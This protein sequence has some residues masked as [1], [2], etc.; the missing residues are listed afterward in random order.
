MGQ[1]I[2]NSDIETDIFTPRSYQIELLDKAKKEN[3]IIPL[4]T[5]TGKTFVAVM[6]IKELSA[7]IRIPFE[8]GGKR[9]F[10]LVDKVALVAQQAEQIR[11][12]SDL[13]VGEHHGM[14]SVDIWNSDRWRE[15]LV[16]NQ[17]I[18][19]TA[20]IFYDLLNHGFFRM[21]QV[22]LIVFDECH[23]ASKNHPYNLIMK[24]YIETPKNKRP[25]ILGLTAS[26][27]NERC[28]PKHLK[29][30][31]S[32]LEA[33]LY[34]KVQSSNDV[35]TVSKYG[36]KP[37]IIVLNAQDFIKPDISY[38]IDSLLKSGLQFCKTADYHPEFDVDPTKPVIEA[39][40]K[41]I[42][43]HDQMG[44]WCFWKVSRFFSKNLRKLEQY[45]LTNE[46][47]S[48]LR[49]GASCLELC[50]KLVESRCSSIRK[51]DDVLPYISTR[52]KRLV[53]VLEREMPAQSVGKDEIQNDPEEDEENNE[54]N[55]KQRTRPNRVDFSCLVFVEQRCVAFA[56]KIFLKDLKRWKRYSEKPLNFIRP[57]YIVGYS[58]YKLNEDEALSLHRRQEEVLKKFRLGIINLICTTSVLEE[59]IDVK[60]C[61]LVVRYDAP[62]NFRSFVQSR[63]RARK[64]NS[65]YYILCENKDKTLIICQLQQFNQI[66]KILL[67]H[68]S[69][70]EDPE[71]LEQFDHAEL[72]TIVPPYYVDVTDKPHIVGKPRVSMLTAIALVNR[73]CARLP[74]D[75]F[76]KLVPKCIVEPVA[77]SQ[78]SNLTCLYQATLRL[79]IN[80]P[81]KREVVVRVTSIP[82]ASKRLAQMAASLEACKILHKEGELDDNLLPLGKESAAKVLDFLIGVDDD[83][84]DA[85]HSAHIRP[86]SSKRKRY[87][88]KQI[89]QCLTNAVPEPDSECYLHVI[90]L[91]LNVSADKIVNY[92][93]TSI[94]AKNRKITD[95]HDSS[96]WFGILSSKALPTLPRFPLYT[97]QGEVLCKVYTSRKKVT[98]S[99]GQMVLVQKF[100]EYLFSEILRLDKT[101]M[102][103][104]PSSVYCNNTL[105]IVPILRVLDDFE[106]DYQFVCNITTL[107][108][109]L[110][111][112]PSDFERMNFKFD[113]EKFLDSVVMPW[114]RNN[115]TPYFYYVAEII[116]RSSPKSPFP[117]NVYPSFNDYFEQK[118]GLT[119]YNQDQNLLDV[120]YTSNRLNLMLPRNF[121]RR[122]YE[123]SSPYTAGPSKKIDNNTNR[124]NINLNE[125]Q[126]IK[127]PNVL[128]AYNQRQVLVP[129]LVDIHPIPGIMWH[130]I[131]CLP[132]V[133]Y[134]LNSLLNA[135]DLR[136]QIAKEAFNTDEIE[137]DVPDEFWPDL[138]YGWQKNYATIEEIPEQNNTKIVEEVRKEHVVNRA[139]TTAI[140]PSIRETRD[141]FDI[142]VWDPTSPD[143]V[144]ILAQ[145]EVAENDVIV[146]TISSDVNNATFSEDNG[147]R[148]I[149]GDDGDEDDD[150]DEDIYF[151]TEFS[152]AIMQIDQNA[153]SGRTLNGESHYKDLFKP[154]SNIVPTGWGDES[155][156]MKQEESG[157]RKLELLCTPNETSFLNT[158]ALLQD[159]VS[160]G[161]GLPPPLL[162]QV[163]NNGDGE[164]E[165]LT[166]SAPTNST[167]S[168]NQ[169]DKPQNSNLSPVE[170]RDYDDI[171]RLTPEDQL[172]LND[173]IDFNASIIDESHNDKS[174]LILIYN[175]E[176]EVYNARPKSISLKETERMIEDEI[177]L[178]DFDQPIDNSKVENLLSD[179]MTEK[180]SKIEKQSSILDD[181]LNVASKSDEHLIDFNK[182][183][184]ENEKSLIATIDQHGP[185]NL[186]GTLMPIDKSVV[187][188]KNEEVSLIEEPE[189]LTIFDQK[190]QDRS[191]AVFD[192]EMDARNSIIYGPSPSLI[193]QALTM[194]NA[195]DGFNLERLE[196]VGD[197]FLKY[198]VTMFLFCQYDKMHE[199][200]LSFLRSKQVSNFNLYKLGKKKGLGKIICST[201][202]EPCDN[203]LPPGYLSLDNVD[204]DETKYE[205]YDNLLE[206]VLEND[207][208]PT[209]DGTLPNADGGPSL[210]LEL[211][212]PPG[213]A[214][215]EQQNE[216]IIPYNLLTQHSVPDK[217]IADSVEALI[218]VYL[219]TYGPKGALQFMKW[220]GLKVLPEGADHFVKPPSPLLHFVDDPRSHLTELW[221]KFNFGHFERIIGY[222]FNDKAYVIQAFTHAS[223]YYNRITDCYQRL[224]FLGDAVLDY[225]ITRHLFEDKRK[226]S[227]GVL[228]DLR[229]AL[230]NNTIFAS[231]AVKWKLNQFFMSICPGL[232]TII[233]SFVDMQEQRQNEANFDEQLYLLNEEDEIDDEEEDIEVPK[234]LG[235]V[236]ESIAGAIYL[237]SGCSL[238]TVWKVYH[239][240]MK[241]QIEK[242][243]SN[244]P[245]S[246]IREL[247]ELCPEKVKFSKHERIVTAGKIRVMVDVQDVGRFTGLGRSYRIAKCTA[248]KRALKHL[249]NM[250]R[251]SQKSQE[252]VD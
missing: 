1:R 26:L 79:P 199:G 108:G 8:K 233:K 41:A 135:D 239:R 194:T 158:G 28:D 21:D 141:V 17:V 118:Y 5:G 48:F 55:E 49:S 147:H 15:E 60:Q 227:P 170:N 176:S 93:K 150:D 20:Q 68:C 63:G 221:T 138:D 30:A 231:L 109:D 67:E 11:T 9:S 14:K 52:L 160:L 24:H 77:T 117:D 76:T 153:R 130:I 85:R 151:S 165:K 156:P 31:I 22:N 104:D 192:F 241:D 7:D 43:V 178:I 142:G 162:P 230:V 219:T 124:S 126:E 27:I 111:R 200:K 25:R 73:Y 123:K 161:A 16:Q 243:C 101:T 136:C 66:E 246:P 197:S 53:D 83:E 173:L 215:V 89:A 116:T 226:H 209:A 244:P 129:E 183:I 80:S 99:A 168:G 96:R 145:E 181:L 112:K 10:F 234:S 198:A 185:I 203:W 64:K 159:L 65:K 152:R 146:A 12:N 166:K 220:L 189:P 143:V 206:K 71:S 186:N 167:T 193:L 195:A 33:S 56:L 140:S 149:N 229:S 236:F 225:L 90:E 87:Y 107:V 42:A 34:S 204:Q 208:L 113:P 44:A 154:S 132:S 224:E 45:A 50:E 128:T 201:K 119:I 216:L 6:L 92:T 37:Q 59:G 36:A 88:I 121:N 217:S 125:S 213:S 177:T 214:W 133:L 180:M 196:T 174:N 110:P 190:V 237:D 94:M 184:V 155:L 223:Y 238:N 46:Q 106:F 245:K 240:L 62:G 122:Q 171:D 202:F 100:H 58:G 188:L 207:Q 74:S 179:F 175:T 164:K 23:H 103:Y 40:T 19:M 3:I 242:C 232:H 182:S 115:E 210:I 248:A 222:T 105:Y 144:E 218:G 70:D 32:K 4:G 120:D 72:D 127:A 29:E 97:R 75:I 137:L 2:R 114:Y 57:D 38:K 84:E 78:G 54:N 169:N 61:N 102:R 157:S 82:T 251:E 187:V 212:K 18:V 39:L 249:K 47:K 139:E 191:T 95:P 91:K 134:R 13:I 98:L 235:D 69:S 51:F 252:S 205:L 35:T 250:Q 81:V 163:V 172:N 86:G 148:T 228:T 247:L 211:P 131:V